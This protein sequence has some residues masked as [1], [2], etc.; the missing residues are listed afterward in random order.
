MSTQN[1]LILTR[2]VERVLASSIGALA[3]FL[4]YKLFATVTTAESVASFKLAN[5]TINMWHVYPGVLF[6]L[7]GAS[8]VFFTAARPASY[9]R[10]IVQNADGVV[11]TEETIRTLTETPVLT[12]GASARNG[13][14][15]EELVKTLAEMANELDVSQASLKRKVALREARV[16]LMGAGWKREWGRREDFNDWVYNSA[17]GDPP[18][19][20]VTRAAAVYCGT[21]DHREAGR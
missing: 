8:L 17:E 15:G 16:A 12:G 4:G 7:F 19:T 13:I 6:A 10:K 21:P 11:A 2:A 5:I 14:A 3:I 1:I 9:V 20:A 18:P